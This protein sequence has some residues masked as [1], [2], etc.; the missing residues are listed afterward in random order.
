[1]F[2]GIGMPK[3]GFKLGIFRLAIVAPLILPM[4]LAYGLKGAAVTVTLGMAGQWLA[5]LVY[6]RAQIG[7]HMSELARTLWRPTWTA[8]LMASLVYTVRLSFDANSAYSL[9]AMLVC[10]LVTYAGLNFRQIMAVKAWS[11][12]SA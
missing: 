11:N 2:E 9:A 1:L 5:S 7:V 4:S 3:I 12:R 6:L 10:G 8:A